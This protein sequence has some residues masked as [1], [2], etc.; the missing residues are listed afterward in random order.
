MTDD[1]RRLFDDLDA[2]IGQVQAG[3]ISIPAED[4]DLPEVVGMSYEERI[5]VRM[6]NT[7]VTKVEIQPLA[8]RLDNESLGEHLA[9]AFNQ[10]LEASVAQAVER[11]AGQ[12]TDLGNLRKHLRE[13]QADSLRSMQNYTNQLEFMLKQVKT[14]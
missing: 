4:P 2:T 7:R 6:K 1:Y 8:M 10:A 13:I 11:V 12:N 5:V 9:E 3:G 14:L